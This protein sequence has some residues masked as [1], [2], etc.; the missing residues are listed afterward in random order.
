MNSWQKYN[1]WLS[2]AWSPICGSC[3][4]TFENMHKQD[5][6]MHVRFER[7]P[8]RHTK[9]KEREA[10]STTDGLCS[11]EHGLWAISFKRSSMGYGGFVNFL[12]LCSST[13]FVTCSI[14]W[15]YGFVMSLILMVATLQR[16]I[17]RPFHSD[18]PW[19]SMVLRVRGLG[20]SLATLTVGTYENM[21]GGGETTKLE[22]IEG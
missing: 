18:D 10:L 15:F 2:E 20:L 16:W 3:Q 4:H 6:I 14:I 9:E 11:S 17:A 8:K 22:L 1:A 7:H 13:N 21:N 5:S 12:L 19:I